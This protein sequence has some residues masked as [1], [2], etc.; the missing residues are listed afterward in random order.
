MYF[1]FYGV[2][3]M[4]K[5]TILMIL[6]LGMMSGGFY[7]NAFA[8]NSTEQTAENQ[9]RQECILTRDDA[10]K[11]IEMIKMMKTT[12]AVIVYT[13]IL[14]YKIS[15]DVVSNKLKSAIVHEVEFFCFIAILAE[16]LKV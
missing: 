4:K 2:N 3:D 15:K 16:I 10:D 1:L 12:I 11:M 5:N 6:A 13:I 8:T 9:Q 7:N 14:G